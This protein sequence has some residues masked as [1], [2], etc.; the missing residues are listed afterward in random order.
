MRICTRA[1]PTACFRG[2]RRGTHQTRA[3]SSCRSGRSPPGDLDTLTERVRHRL[4]RWFRR[5]G[6]LDAEA[7][8]DMLSWEPS[9]AP[10]AQGVVRFSPH[11][12]LDRLA[13]LVPPPQK[14][15]HRYQGVFAPNHPL[16]PLVK[17]LAIGNAGKSAVK[18]TRESDGAC[19]TGAA[20]ERRSHDTSK[21]CSGRR[22]REVFDGSEPVHRLGK[23]RSSPIGCVRE[24]TRSRHH[25]AEVPLAVLSFDG[26]AP[27]LD[28]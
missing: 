26:L 8:A 28:Y 16:R 21:Q 13:D 27:R 15:R 5:A 9:G 24:P 20:D 6:L 18:A 23:S 17:A 1:S 19:P 11:E 4:M 10:A 25:V 3:S 7:A 22:L 2:P 14:H 12:F